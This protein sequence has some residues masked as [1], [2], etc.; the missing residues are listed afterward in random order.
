MEDERSADPLAVAALEHL[1]GPSRGTVT[2]LSGSNMCISLSTNRFIRVSE[3]RPGEPPD[4]LV[5][6]LHRAGDT[7]E[8]EAVEARPVWVNGAR[9]S[10]GKLEHGATIEFGG[11]LPQAELRYL[12][13]VIKVVLAS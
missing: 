7:Y 5:A 6:R 8:I 10:A 4:D 3:A 1:T 13:G 11:H 2:W 9:V 12:H